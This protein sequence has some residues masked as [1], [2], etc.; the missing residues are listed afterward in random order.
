MK[1]RFSTL[2]LLLIAVVLFSNCSKEDDNLIKLSSPTT[3]T[4][5]HEQTSQIDV[6][7]LLAVDYSSENEF[8]AKVTSSGKVTANYVG[9]TTITLSNGNDSKSIKV[10]VEPRH[11]LYPSPCTDWGA[12]KRDVIAMHGTPDYETDKGIG[13]ENYSTSA[14]IAMFVFDDSG[15]LASSATMVKTSYSSI[16]TDYLLER[17]MPAIV[18]TEEYTAM[19]INALTTEETTTAILLSIYNLSYFQVFYTDARNVASHST[20]TIDNSN[21]KQLKEIADEMISNQ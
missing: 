12:T 18:D 7:S 16:L 20:R 10:I 21:I 11:N 5:H 14:P 13:Y 15:R 8:H 2:S 4:L 17:Y 1:T 9:E 6:I 19:F 3:I